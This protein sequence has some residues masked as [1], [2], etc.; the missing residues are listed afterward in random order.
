MSAAATPYRARRSMVRGSGVNLNRMSQSRGGN[1]GALEDSFRARSKFFACN[2]HIDEVF[3]DIGSSAVYLMNGG[4]ISPA[5][6]IICARAGCGFQPSKGTCSRRIQS[7]RFPVALES[8][9]VGRQPST[10]NPGDADRC[11]DKACSA[12]PPAHGLSTPWHILRDQ[13]S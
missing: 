10:R 1:D 3:L 4:I 13:G 6:K 8:V 7:H 11:H 2:P 9:V 12:T 5:G